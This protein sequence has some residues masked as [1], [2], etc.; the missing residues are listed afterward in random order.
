MFFDP[1]HFLYSSFMVTFFTYQYFRDVKI[2]ITV[3]FAVRFVLVVFHSRFFI[4]YLLK[5]N[6]NNKKSNIFQL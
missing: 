3:T 5:L 4:M 1:N 6:N 2:K